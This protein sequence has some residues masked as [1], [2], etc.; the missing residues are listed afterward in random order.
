MWDPPRPGIEPMSRALAG[1]VLTTAPP[2][3]SQ[4]VIKKKKKS[5]WGI[6]GPGPKPVFPVLAGGF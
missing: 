5:M 4:K 1:R 3:E 2:E 6:P